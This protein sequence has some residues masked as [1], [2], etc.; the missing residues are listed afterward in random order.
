MPLG[1]TPAMQLSCWLGQMVAT[2]LP[3]SNAACSPAPLA[4]QNICGS[5]PGTVERLAALAPAAAT[6]QRSSQVQYCAVA[7]QQLAKPCQCSASYPALLLCRRLARP[8]VF[9][10]MASK[11]A[12]CQGLALMHPAL[13]KGPRHL[14]PLTATASPSTTLQA[15]SHQSSI[16]LSAAATG[17]KYACSRYAR[18]AHRSSLDCCWV[19]AG[20]HAP[21]RC[22]SVSRAQVACLAEAA[23]P[24]GKLFRAVATHTSTAAGLTCHRATR[25]GICDTGRAGCLGQ[26][27]LR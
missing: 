8:A 15:G 4:R 11:A 19:F 12:A 14:S 24:G 9:T 2:Q 5:R 18:A 20:L 26:V 17:N 23:C 22:C 21:A 27:A 10:Q 16:A 6:R 13:L 25:T 1:T 7:E 3:H